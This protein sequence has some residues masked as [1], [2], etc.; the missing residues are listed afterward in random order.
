MTRNS[1]GAL[2]FPVAVNRLPSKGITV[3][4]DANEKEREA[5]RTFHELEDVKSFKAD[6]Q[7]VPWKKDGIRVR[8]TVNAQIVQAC[9]VTLDPI[10]ATVEAQIDTLFVPENSRLARPPLDENGELVISAEGPD[11]PETFT[12]DRLDA[13]AIA[14]EFFELAIDPY[15]RKPDVVDA[16]P[17]VV[18]IGDDDGSEKPANPFATLK[19]WKQKT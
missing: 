18:S 5:L 1:D 13:G 2:S 19:D 12:G 9:I 8:G 10:D 7:I 17:V 15:P 14:E 4:I 3:K 6:L 16:P 11:T